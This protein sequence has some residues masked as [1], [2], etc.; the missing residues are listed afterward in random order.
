MSFGTHSEHFNTA[1]VMKMRSS[2]RH[3]QNDG[4]LYRVIS[5]LPPYNTQ[6][7]RHESTTWMTSSFTGNYDNSVNW[8]RHRN[9]Q[10]VLEKWRRRSPQNMTDDHLTDVDIYYRLVCIRRESDMNTVTKM[11]APRANSQHMNRQ[12]IHIREHIQLPQ[13][14]LERYTITKSNRGLNS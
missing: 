12:C 4:T 11:A 2:V 9:W 10:S 3:C 14:Q 1:I 5:S 13:Q 8:W 6:Q 7:G